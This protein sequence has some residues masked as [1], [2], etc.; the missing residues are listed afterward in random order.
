V[1]QCL[2]IELWAKEL[3]RPDRP[4]DMI[5][6]LMS[7]RSYRPGIEPPSPPPPLS[8]IEGVINRGRP[9]QSIIVCELGA[10]FCMPEVQYL[11]SNSSV[12][13]TTM[14]AI[15]RNR[16]GVQDYASTKRAAIE[17]AERLRAERRGRESQGD[18]ALDAHTSSTPVKSR[19]DMD[20]RHYQHGEMAL[21]IASNAQADALAAL[22]G[23]VKSPSNP[24]PTYDHY[25]RHQGGHQADALDGLVGT[26]SRN[27]RGERSHEDPAHDGRGFGRR[28][29]SREP[30]ARCLSRP[31]TP[32]YDHTAAAAA[33]LVVEEFLFSRIEMN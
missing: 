21:A 25:A 19:R 30:P 12:T 18:D 14:N 10:V 4:D 27:A 26:P 33:K 29:A 11:P 7:T 6:F 2:T 8:R 24:S 13:A 16:R 15:E 22:D 23:L 1:V 32:T 3:Y 31:H 20:A 28:Q 17:R 5:D 9:S